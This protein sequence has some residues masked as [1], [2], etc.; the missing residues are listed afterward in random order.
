MKLL[1]ELYDYREMIFSLVQRDLKGRYKGSLLGFLWTFLNPLLQLCVYTL[2]FS[3]IMRNGIEDFYLFLFVALVPWMF[4]SACVASAA[5]LIRAQ[6]DMVK[7]IYFPREVL[8]VAFVTSQFIN[9]FYSLLVVLAVLMIAG[10]G[11][12]IFAVLSL[13]IIMVI[14]YVMALGIALITSAITVYFRDMEYLLGII[15]MAWQFLTPIFY[16]VDMV[17]ARLMPVFNLN[18]M[19]SVII[20]YRDILYYKQL[21]KM[22]TLIQAIICG[23]LLL[24]AGLFVFGRLKR[25]FAEEL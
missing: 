12:N 8:P 9:M 19:T 13:P 17:P 14:E 4:F 24:A 23:I 6:Q 20:A 1:R 10:K 21:P 25:H 15:T 18:P 7:K 3:V 2:V 22:E 11:I 5:G 16:S